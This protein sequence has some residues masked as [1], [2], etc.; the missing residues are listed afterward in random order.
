[1]CKKL[2][3]FW[4]ENSGIL[5]TSF[6]PIA[7]RFWLES[8]YYIRDCAK[9]RKKSAPI[10]E[11]IQPNYKRIA[12]KKSVGLGLLLVA[13][14]GL[15]GVVGV[16]AVVAGATDVSGPVSGTWTAANNP[17][18]VLGELNVPSG[19]TLNIQ[20]GVHVI[21]QGHF[22]FNVSQDATLKALGTAQDTI[23]FTASNIS[24]GWHGIRFFYPAPGCS[25]QY[26]HFA[27]GNA[28]DSTSEDREGGALY[29]YGFQTSFLNIHHCLIEGCQAADGGA[30]Y[31]GYYN[32]SYCDFINNSAMFISGMGGGGGAISGANGQLSHCT[33]R[34]NIAQMWGGCIY[35]SNLVL[36]SCIIDGNYAGYGGAIYNYLEDCELNYCLV[37][38]NMANYCGGGIYAGNYSTFRLNHTQIIN[39]SAIYIPGDGGGLY[40]LAANLG[41]YFSTISY[42]SA[43]GVGG[44]LGISNGSCTIDH[45]TICGNSAQYTAGISAGIPITIT[46][47]SI[48]ENYASINYGGLYFATS[49]VST[50]D[51]TIVWG[52][53]PNQIFSYYNAPIIAYSDVQD[54]IWPG[55]GNINS[56]PAFV[57]TVNGDYRLQWGSTCID[58][59]DP[60]VIYNDPDNTRSD[61]GAYFFDQRNSVRVL[62]T[63]HGQPIQIPVGGGSFSFDVRLTNIR[64]TAQQALVW[65]NTTLPNGSIYGPTLGP[66]QVNLT[67][68]ATVSRLRTQTIPGSAP[69]GPYSYNAFAV[70]NQDTSRDNFIFIKSEYGALDQSGNDWLCS[71]SS[72]PG[73]ETGIRVEQALP[74]QFGVVGISPNPFNPSTTIRFSL[75][76]ATRATLNVYDITGRHVAQLVN[77]LQPAGIHQ[78]TFD[79]SNLPSG[80][81]LY[82]LTAGQNSA[83]GKMVLLK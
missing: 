44:G 10:H 53:Q 34:G 59:G 6:S 4:T 35:G 31:M 48:C 45:S 26:C 19:Q 83:A 24:N 13:G 15:A 9:V 62:L 8:A 56:W 79:G 46:N 28:Y 29:F 38:N 58:S 75:P 2:R 41:I 43:G 72:F 7:P 21:F 82:R 70:S 55:V 50:V 63:P 37:S 27:Y 61:I 47:S 77:G 14:L 64:T 40:C 32:M 74:L 66:V 54:T 78:V 3:L 30:I 76:E 42:N 22:K 36:D 39:N 52:N 12:M 67:F 69:Q 1:M 60:S 17:Y 33:F 49:S 11:D 81:Y 18:N 5:I 80:V 16:L 25:L 51:N 73:E 71:G 20:P 68:G 23:L 57:D 65:C